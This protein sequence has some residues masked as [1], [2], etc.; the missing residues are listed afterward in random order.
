MIYFGFTNGTYMAKI[1][2]GIQNLH[3]VADMAVKYRNDDSV[4]STLFW[5]WAENHKTVGLLNAINH[6]GLCEL[7]DFFN[8]LDNYCPWIS[9]HGD[10]DSMNGI[11]T[12][13]G[14]VLPPKIYETSRTYKKCPEMLSMCR[15]GE[16]SNFSDWEI[17]LIKLLFKY[18]RV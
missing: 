18:H 7:R 9:F 2:H 13:V 16:F 10:E 12:A 15:S 11:L 3:A 4:G 1:Q 6:K 8:S 17:D 5:D 14:I